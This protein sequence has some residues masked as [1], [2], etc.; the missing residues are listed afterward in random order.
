MPAKIP[1][2]QILLQ[3]FTHSVQAI[4]RGKPVSIERTSVHSVYI[5]GKRWSFDLQAVTTSHTK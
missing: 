2:N 4:Q 1:Q 3:L 5:I